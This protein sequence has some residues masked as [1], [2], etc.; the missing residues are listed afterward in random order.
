P[1]R[2]RAAT[3]PR[4][5]GFGRP[6]EQAL[7]RPL[8]DAEAKTPIERRR[9]RVRRQHTKRDGLAAGLE[10]A[11]D[12]RPDSLALIGREELDQFQEDLVAA[13]LDVEDTGVLVVDQDD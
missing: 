5:F 9:A 10:R 13:L 2:P 11:D 8:H 7:R 1:A 4:S 3:S 6:H 12:R